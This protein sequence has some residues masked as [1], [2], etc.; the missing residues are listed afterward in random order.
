MAV[1]SRALVFLSLACS[2]MV[3]LAQSNTCCDD[4]SSFPFPGSGN[5]L[6]YRKNLDGTFSTEGAV[7]VGYTSTRCGSC[8]T[9]S[10]S[11]TPKKCTYGGAKLPSISSFKCS[12]YLTYVSSGFSD[13]KEK[14]NKQPCF[15]FTDI[16]SS[17]NETH[18]QQCTVSYMGV[19]SFDF[20][21]S[22]PSSVAT[23]SCQGLVAAP[24]VCN[25]FGNF[26]ALGT[27][28]YIV[29]SY[30][31][32]STSVLS[33]L[34]LGLQWL[35]LPAGSFSNNLYCS[36]SPYTSRC[37]EKIVTHV[38]PVLKQWRVIGSLL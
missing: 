37:T 31:T 9:A 32:C 3:A 26:F 27:G 29:A 33:K 25:V 19:G 24:K 36:S 21:L 23:V 34:L 15:Y 10:Y 2:I 28:G 8:A 18:Y 20:S 16:S 4:F 14:R 35:L 22:G 38:P 12:Y 1:N 6:N 7:S 11:L 5:N 13:K 30:K 17:V